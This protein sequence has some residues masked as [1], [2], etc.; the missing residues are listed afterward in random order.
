MTEEKVEL[1]KIVTLGELRRRTA[2][3][4]DDTVIV[5]ETECTAEWR[6]LSP[7]LKVMPG[8]KGVRRRGRQGDDWGLADVPDVLILDW[9]QEV[10]LEYAIEQRYDESL[11]SD[12]G[13]FLP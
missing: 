3:L 10:S 8:Q 6:E 11:E 4:P 12:D 13:G 1:L 2:H 9:G 7:C 5:I